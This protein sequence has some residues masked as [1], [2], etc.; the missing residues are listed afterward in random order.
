VIFFL[1]SFEDDLETLMVFIEKFVPYIVFIAFVIGVIIKM[2]RDVVYKI[3][4]EM[5]KD[6]LM[7][8]FQIL[9]RIYE[10]VPVEKLFDFLNAFERKYSLDADMKDAVLTISNLTSLK[11]PVQYIGKKQKD[12]SVAMR[13]KKFLAR[14]KENHDFDVA[15]E[16]MALLLNEQLKLQ[17]ELT[18]KKVQPVVDKINNII[19]KAMANVPKNREKRMDAEE[20]RREMDAAKT[21]AE[22]TVIGKRIHGIFKR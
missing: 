5:G 2:R 8:S 7:L 18:K 15:L 19:E 16:R 13:N 21:D 4:N 3:K 17:S 22:K 9:K 11:K 12:T 1:F 10:V 20:A 14:L 6:A